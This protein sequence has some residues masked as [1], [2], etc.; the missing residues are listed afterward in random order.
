MRRRC[1]PGLHVFMAITQN[2]IGHGFTFILTTPRTIKTTTVHAR[3]APSI[4]PGRT[5]GGRNVTKY[6]DFPKQILR[7]MLYCWSHRL[8]PIQIKLFES[9]PMHN[10]TA[11]ACFPSPHLASS[12]RENFD[13][14]AVGV[15]PSLRADPS[16]R[17][18]STT[19]KHA[20]GHTHAQGQERKNKYSSIPQKHTTKHA[21]IVGETRHYLPKR[22]IDIRKDVPCRCKKKKKM[23]RAP[24]PTRPGSA[25]SYAQTNNV[26]KKRSNPHG[27][28]LNSRA[29]HSMKHEDKL[30]ILRSPYTT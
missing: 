14:L 25:E 7:K 12:R 30:S 13:R 10:T 2:K 19:K 20:R 9:S 24:C 22:L 15:P 21:L 29:Q 6:M 17:H 18:P 4:R 23:F 8:Y 27:V 1:L 26:K 11:T 5:D 3:R 28:K 16:N